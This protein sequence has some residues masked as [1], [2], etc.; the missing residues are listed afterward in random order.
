MTDH[1][2]SNVGF[3]PEA[4]IPQMARWANRVISHCRKTVSL[5]AVGAENVSLNR[6]LAVKRFLFF[7]RPL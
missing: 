1:A 5:F 3:A 4:T 6:S 7:E 2:Q